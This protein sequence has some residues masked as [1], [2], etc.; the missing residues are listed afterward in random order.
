MPPLFRLPQGADPLAWLRPSPRLKT[1]AAAF[2]GFV[3]H[4]DINHPDA[5]ALS[6]IMGGS[7]NRDI[8]TAG[9][10]APFTSPLNSRALKTRVYAFMP[11]K[12][13]NTR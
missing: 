4:G 5:R 6:R 11:A 7:F 1:H 8:I 12:I 3:A 10:F 9:G 2:P 13:I